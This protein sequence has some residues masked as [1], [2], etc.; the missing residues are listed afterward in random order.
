MSNNNFNTNIA[1]KRKADD[2]N[3]VSIEN[4]EMQALK[5]ELSKIKAELEDYKLELDGKKAENSDLN[6]ANSDLRAELSDAKKQLEEALE[7]LASGSNEEDDDD[8]ADDEESAV[9]DSSDPWHAKYLEL[10]TYRTINGDCNV[11]RNGANSK[12]GVWVNNQR[13]AYTNVKSGKKGSQISQE[14]IALLD[15]LGFFWGKKFGPPVSWEERYNEIKQ[16]KQSVG[17]CN[18]PIHEANPSP[19]ATWVLAQRSEYRRFRK[20]QESLL[21]LDQIGQLKE[22]SFKW[23]A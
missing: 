20:G 12:L 10:R 7:N 22:I 15:G 13:Q 14:R 18:I 11:P 17:N 16:Y 21:S 23:K 8:F 9:I 19:L 6:A 4:E 2:H 1:K 3:F 5:A